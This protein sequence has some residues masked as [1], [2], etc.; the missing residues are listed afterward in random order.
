M[1]VREA[2]R[3]TDI[4][5]V[6]F[7]AGNSVGWT[8]KRLRLTSALAQSQAAAKRVGILLCHA[9]EEGWLLLGLLKGG[10]EQRRRGFRLSCSGSAR[11]PVSLWTGAYE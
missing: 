3:A 9:A 11:N 4:R 10:A 8:R 6:N 2:C 1:E 7:D 5:N